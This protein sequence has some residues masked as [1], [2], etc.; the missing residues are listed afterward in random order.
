MV[1]L[2]AYVFVSQSSIPVG[3][4]DSDISTIWFFFLLAVSQFDLDTSAICFLFACV[5]VS[6]SSIPV[7]QLDSDTS[8]IWYSFNLGL[9]KQLF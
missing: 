2:F 5:F 7:G 6:Q 9:N 4:F 8:T 1:F 3:Q